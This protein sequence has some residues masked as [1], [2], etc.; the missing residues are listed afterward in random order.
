MSPRKV[1]RNT[2]QAEHHVAQAEW[3]RNGKHLLPGAGITLHTTMLRKDGHKQKKF[4]YRTRGECLCP[5]DEDFL[6]LGAL[7]QSHSMYQRQAPWWQNI[8]RKMG[9]FA[10][11]KFMGVRAPEILGCLHIP[12]TGATKLEHDGMAAQIGRAISKF[13][14]ANPQGFALKPGEGFAGKGVFIFKKDTIVE[15]NGMHKANQTGSVSLSHVTKTI[16][17]GKGGWQLEELVASVV[18]GK[19]EDYKFLMFGDKIGMIAYV[20]R[21]GNHDCHAATDETMSFRFENGTNCLGRMVEFGDKCSRDFAHQNADEEWKSCT[22]HQM[23]DT[24][25]AKANRAKPDPQAKRLWDETVAAVKKMGGVI[26]VHMR[27]DMFIGPDGPVLGEFTPF[28]RNNWKDCFVGPPRTPGGPPDRCYLGKQWKDF[29][30][31]NE[32]AESKITLQA[33]KPKGKVLPSFNN[34]SFHD[35]FFQKTNLPPGGWER[36]CLAA[37]MTKNNF[38]TWGGAATGTMHNQN[39]LKQTA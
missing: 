24:I 38:Y 37:G 1:E 26:N 29:G 5:P 9:G 35:V 8:N 33:L 16:A 2:T 18:P 15:V 34:V 6:A 25:I 30:F 4:Q 21:A 11:A 12:T 32:H 17:K 36:K 28:H 22:A 23:K 31:A 27:I 19:F 14:K 13:K 3:I 10:F 20:Q 7:R 39:M